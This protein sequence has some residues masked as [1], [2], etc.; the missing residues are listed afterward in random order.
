M[1]RYLLLLIFISIT[2]LPLAGTGWCEEKPQVYSNEDI[3]KYRNPSDNRSTVQKR[4]VA[5][6]KSGEK[7]IAREKQDQEQWCRRATA[8]RRKI[9]LA[10]HELSET[11]KDIARE[12]EKKVQTS[13]KKSSL[14]TRY[15]K[16]QYNLSRAEM[17][18]SDLEN[19]AHRKGIKPGWLRC[20]FD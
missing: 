4:D 20:Q 14:R 2:L 12:N 16:A 11:E 6:E 13:G 10:K 5:A 3:E 15:K 9:D 19:E 1:K 7:K 8:L 17:D 18:L